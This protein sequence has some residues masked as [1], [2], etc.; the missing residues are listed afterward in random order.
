D[1]IA[2]Y[3]ADPAGFIAN[4]ANIDKISRLTG[5]SAPDVVA[6]LKGNRF[7]SRDEQIRLLQQPFVTAVSNTASFL[8]SQGKVD[9][10]L[11]DYNPYVTNRF[12]RQAE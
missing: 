10:V 9:T 4:G 2:Q 11:A 7:L 12:V 5:A 6:G 1:S 3:R 8:K